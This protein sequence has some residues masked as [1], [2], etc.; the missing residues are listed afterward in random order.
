MIGTKVCGCV[1]LLMASETN[2]LKN[3]KICHVW[4]YVANPSF[5]GYVNSYLLWN[6]SKFQGGKVIVL[7]A[8]VGKYSKAE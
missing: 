3:R 4:N 8:F 6:L 5:V 7:M 2:I 1:S